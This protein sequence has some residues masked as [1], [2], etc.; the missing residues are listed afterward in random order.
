[1]P[2]NKAFWAL[3]DREGTR[4]RAARDWRLHLGPRWMHAPVRRTA[5]VAERVECPAT[6][7]AWLDV[8]EEE[9]GFVLVP[10]D[11]IRAEAVSPT[12]IEVWVPDWRRMAAELAEAHEFN[13]CEPQ[14]DG[15]TRRIGIFHSA[16]CPRRDVFLHVCNRFLGARDAVL[17]EIG[18][19]RDCVLILTSDRFADAAI[20]EFAHSRGV[21]I[22]TVLGGGE[23][24]LNAAEVVAKPPAPKATATLPLFAVRKD[25]RW[26]RLKV[27]ANADF[28]RFIYGGR[29]ARHS[30]R[31]DN[32][33]GTSKFH[34]ILL[35]IAD[36]GA[37]GFGARSDHRRPARKRSL[38]R[39]SCELRN[40]VPIEGEPFEIDFIEARP[41]F[42]IDLDPELVGR[43]RRVA[44][45]QTDDGEDDF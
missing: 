44:A 13:E 26:S 11:S 15:D 40:L 3:L 17:R 2:R 39:L 41:V 25:W 10:E 9:G 23:P 32:R 16:R 6:A 33:T 34:E 30:F 42:E 22:H 14:G 19:L 1:M 45:G 37:F 38:Q 20:K 35:L 8:R 4:G 24:S 36:K 43:F 7:G 21:K 5:A 12:D 31:V 18:R 29:K 28:V 27:Q